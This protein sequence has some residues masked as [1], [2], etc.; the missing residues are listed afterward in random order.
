MLRLL[1]CPQG[2]F[3]E[4]ADATRCPQCGAPAD[5]LPVLDLEA[6]PPRDTPPPVPASAAL[7]LFDANGWPV[8]AGYEIQ[9]DAGKGPTG[10]RL[11]E[12][13]HK[14]INRVVLLEVVLAREDTSQFAWSSLRS[15]A[16]ALARLIHPGVP[17]LYEVGE[18]DRQIFYNAVELVEGPT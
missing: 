17:Q 15:Q 3:W 1:T 4:S 7:D 18:R 5:S 16:A 10:M 2:H 14:V 13:K 8:V 11:Y 6:E 12:A 9:E